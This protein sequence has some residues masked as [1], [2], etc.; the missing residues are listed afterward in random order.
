MM[1]V[2]PKENYSLF[3]P[4]YEIELWHIIVWVENGKLC[5]KNKGMLDN[6]SHTK[7]KI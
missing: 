2:I 3:D 7:G 1:N 6:W 4:I 5:I